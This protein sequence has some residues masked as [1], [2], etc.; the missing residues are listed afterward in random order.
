MFRGFLFYG[1]AMAFRGGRAGWITAA[2]IQ[3]VVFGAAH[4]YHFLPA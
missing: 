3:S 1:L 2:V 4:G